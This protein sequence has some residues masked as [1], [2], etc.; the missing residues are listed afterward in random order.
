MRSRPTALLLLCLFSAFL[1]LTP[2]SATTVK[3]RVNETA[4]RVWPRQTKTEVAL[5][6]ENLT[7][8]P[9]RANIELE[10]L[11]PS[12]LVDG[13]T[14]R[15]ETIAPGAGKLTIPFPLPKEIHE[16]DKTLW[17]RL[18]YR[19]APES[20]N[21]FAPVSGII[22]LSEIT[23]DLFEL[24]VTAS[25]F[26]IPGKTYRTHIRALHPLTSRPVGGVSVTAKLKFDNDRQNSFT[27]AGVTN[28]QG[29][30]SLDFTLPRDLIAEDG[31]VEIKASR[32]EFKQE[33]EFETRDDPRGMNRIILTT[34]KPIYQPGQTL[35]VRA[36]L[37]D[38]I[39][40]A[41]PNANL[42][43]T[44]SDPE[45][46]RQF[47]A[48]LKTSRFGVANVDWQIP[49]NTRLGEYSINLE[50]DD[51]K[52]GEARMETR[53]KISRYDLPNFAVKT[54]SDR[55]FYLPGQN[56]EITISADYLFGQ[57]VTKGKA[58]IVREGDERW[59]SAQQKY[60]REEVETFEGELDASGRFVAKI[61]LTEAFRGLRNDSWQRFEDRAY[62]AYLT[63]ATTGR[64]EQKRFDLRITRDP[65]HVYLIGLQYHANENMPLQFYVSTSY[66]DGKPAACEVTIN[67]LIENDDDDEP[68]ERQL[69]KVKTNARGLAKIS[70]LSLPKREDRNGRLE[71]S[72]TAH[73]GKD[74]A[75]HRKENLWL[76]ED[77]A[78]RVETDK[79]IYRPNEPVEVQIKSNAENALAILSVTRDLEVVHS[80]AVKLRGG[81]AFVVIPYRP[82]F[83]G[84][85]G[86]AVTVE[87]ADAD[88]EYHS[89]RASSDSRAVMYPR[90]RELKLDVRMSA[91]EY[92]PGDDG[93]ASFRVT[94][95]EGRPLESVLGV[96]VIDQA[97]EERA[98]TDN[99]FNGRRH[100]NF[101]GYY[102][103][104]GSGLAG[105]TVRDLRKLDVTQPI[106]AE[107]QLI[108]EI[109]LLEYGYQPRIETSSEYQR[110]PKEVFKVFIGRQF[111]SVSHSLDEY[112]EKTGEYPLSRAALNDILRFDKIN[113]DAMLDPWGTPYLAS[114]T[115]EREFDYL[116]AISAGADK[117][118]NTADDFTA[119]TKSWP[120]FAKTGHQIRQAMKQFNEL[121]G[122]ATL[123][124]ALFKE[125]L[126]RAGLDFDALR[127]RWGKQYLLTLSVS[128]TRWL[129]SVHSG[130]ADGK[131]DQ[132][133][134]SY[135]D[136]FVVWVSAL[137]YFER[138][139]SRLDK[140]LA[141]HLRTT[142]EYPSNDEELR[143]ILKANDVEFDNLRDPWGNVFY[144][145]F[146]N[147]FRY[148][149]RVVV[150]YDDLQKKQT[151]IQPVTQR[152][153]AI[154]IRSRG[155]DGEEKTNDDIVV[156]E[157]SQ[158][159]AQMSSHDQQP[160]K[161]DNALMASGLLGEIRGMVT[162]AQGAVIAD[163]TVK[164]ARKE[165]QLEMQT[166][167]DSS[168]NYQFRNLPH[169]NYQLECD[170]PGF[171]K[172]VI[173][174]IRVLPT[175]VTSVNLTLEVGSVSETVMVT[176]AVTQLQTE[177]ASVSVTSKQ[178]ANLPLNA[179]N[180]AN[181]LALSP[182][183]Q[184]GKSELATPRLREHFQETLVW[185]PQLETDKQGRATLKFKMADNITTWKLAAV[186][187]TV[188]GQIGIVET[189]FRAF[190]PFFA[191]HDPPK[192]L[193]EGDEISLPVVLRNYLDKSLTVTTEMKSEP[194]FTL[195]GAARQ[196]T[197]IAAG[198]S[199]NAIFD[200]RV[201]SSTANGK[202]RVT[203]LSADASDAIEK[204]VSV[205][206]DGE[207]M[208]QT[209]GGVF[210][211]IGKL[212]LAIPADAIKSSVRAELKIY[213]NLMTHALEGIE[214][215]LR[216]P[217]GCGEQTI[218]STYP[219][220]LALRYLRQQDESAA[221]LA[222][223]ARR[224]VQAGYERLLG[225]RAPDGGFN[226]WGRGEA[227][228]ALTA[229]AVRFLND[230][231]E[232]AAVDDDVVAKARNWLIAQ[233]QTDGRW[234][235]YSDGYEDQR[236][237][238]L[239]TAYIARVLA[240]EQKR[241]ATPDK[242]LSESLQRAMKFVAERAEEIDEPYLIASF[243]LAAFEA[244][245]TES[246]TKAV[247]K[248][249][250]LARDEAG[251]AYWNLETNTPFYGWG[252]AGRVETT[253]LAVKALQVERAKGKQ[254]EGAKGRVGE[255]ARDEL[256]DR[257]LLF[258]IRNKDRYGVWYSTQAT[259]NVLD[260]M[261]SL[262]EAERIKTSAGGQAEVFVNGNRVGSVAVPSSHKLGNPLTLDV[263]SALNA[264][265]NRIEIRRSGDV[266]LAT[267]QIVETH[268]AAW[269]TGAGET[270]EEAK[271]KSSAL[272]LA[273]G[274]DKPQAKIGEEITC[275]VKA[276]RIGHSGYGM[277]LGE[278]G[279]PPGA[280][281]DR[282]SLE[283]AMKTS[284]WELNQYDVLPDRVVVYLWPRAGGTSF[285][286][287]FKLR[288]G[289]RA[290]SAPS[291]LYDYYNPEARVVVAP[292]RFIAK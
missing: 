170:A 109:L 46:T 29:Y 218:S 152:I 5:A 224:Y 66:A 183:T 162:D 30:V 196:Q 104:T 80:Q 215:I 178:I 287:K 189:E 206:P 278:I 123:N 84:E 122:R 254:G 198:D 147:T 42:K 179:R 128:G 210:A 47:R 158:L 82:A 208:A 85:V 76:R 277:L 259:I 27:T 131:F 261:V 142:G 290:Q 272:R 9:L 236:R 154:S 214:G 258:L 193:T 26:P 74:R 239:T 1:W 284:G 18:R 7:N 197:K 56:A 37:F 90:D 246:A 156:A 181:L 126:K 169:G 143:S 225:Y 276:E 175:T 72:L 91:T 23:P 93:R 120:Y 49:D 121:D 44:I 15:R 6:V 203:A 89:T 249:R 4:T 155:A 58:R 273:V 157:F 207:E 69:R 108:A 200:F 88:G 21:S 282:A 136:D 137:T 32:G 105:V 271:G 129:A 77:L 110:D 75:G 159:I 124:V 213:P 38:F 135:S 187:S 226:Y 61:D 151:G 40:R 87:A 280:D 275:T 34:D 20:D 70:S 263:S 53:V 43:L 195:I 132:T 65:I 279:L 161:V 146:T 59:D 148:G 242:K 28:S 54:K 150:R 134:G 67:E 78:V 96:T 33:I 233:Q 68:I 269:K 223:K 286:F 247:A 251:T 192:I 194:W 11:D 51:D 19:V 73:D 202:Q 81:K 149:D 268:Y 99:E 270:R 291:A 79:A 201:N 115:A 283:S 174:D 222:A 71:L 113:F 48:D 127:D 248:L 62:A 100:Y 253:A 285:S 235:S 164:L 212:N 119:F 264:S 216:R 94:T 107:L 260:T 31:E 172:L 217:Y 173:T 199:A 3:L 262:Y 52:H 14:A 244:G 267:A 118:F 165:T 24:R 45:G 112:F 219:N 186:A 252:L 166:K 227:D 141:N 234:N 177:S 221:G 83:S 238:A 204:P 25:E 22:S 35:H 17:Y 63:D 184:G 92:R 117:K 288:Y 237:S 144:A 168:G 289:L 191:E 130:G 265:D 125:E 60:V 153:N 114:F 145:T 95:A 64:T 292:T 101:T 245:Q 167:S 232:F 243:A 8:R 103:D 39:N 230:A 211:N 16:Q 86:V 182:G 266:T 188:D 50:M 36:L 185:H 163:T 13:K 255:A 160:E 139:A 190:Q 111:M 57:P 10:W 116:H 41:I 256:V 2:S 133:V 231:R 240:A 55:E 98:R 97:V 205:H 140:L 250:Q 281:V 229:Y 106:S 12:D 241:L 209:V 138:T 220:V 257:G 180:A 171:K 228:L 102:L 274:Y 176:G